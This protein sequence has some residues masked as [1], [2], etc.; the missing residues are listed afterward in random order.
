MTVA[1]G[2]PGAQIAQ[3]LRAAGHPVFW[4]AER[5]SHAR[6]LRGKDS[7]AWWDMAGRIHL[8]L[9]QVPE[10]L[11]GVRARCARPGRRNSR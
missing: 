10:V 5:A 2:Q 4:S 7:V 9:S 6:R 8:H 1:G 11:A 3:D